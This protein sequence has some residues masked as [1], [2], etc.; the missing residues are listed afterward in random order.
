MQRLAHNVFV[1]ALAA[2]VAGC[3]SSGRTT[4]VESRGTVALTTAQSFRDAMR[5]LWSD[6]VVWTREYIVA[7]VADHPSAKAAST[8]LLKNQE[9]IGK[10]IVPYYSADAGNKL[11]DLLKQH[12][13]IAVDLVAAAKAND[14]SKQADADKRWHTNA[15][16]IA[17]FLSGAN[18][19]WPKQ[20]LLDMLNEHLTLT[21]QEAVARLKGNWDEDVAAF[22]K[23]YMQAMKMADALSDGIIKQH[24]TMF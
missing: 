12:I 17:T 10:A 24:A 2:L 9:D 13:L 4:T 3:A 19:N 11:T 15:E 7:A 23:I 8:R 20:T 22:D 6:H 14:A 21:T 16:E 1:A 18:P 5:V